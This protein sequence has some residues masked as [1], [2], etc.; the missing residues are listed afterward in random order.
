MEEPMK[1]GVQRMS[2][3]FRSEF[4]EENEQIPL[5]EQEH[6]CAKHGEQDDS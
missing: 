4:K 6:S 3:E 5:D 2:A 1:L